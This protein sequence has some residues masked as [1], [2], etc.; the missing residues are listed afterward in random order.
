MR[1]AF[2]LYKM[3][4][5]R[6]RSNI[7]YLVLYFVVCT[8]GGGEGAGLRNSSTGSRRRRA[9]GSRRSSRSRRPACCP[10]PPAS[11]QLSTS[12]WLGIRRLGVMLDAGLASVPERWVSAGL[13]S[14]GMTELG[15]HQ[16][17]RETGLVPVLKRWVSAG[18]AL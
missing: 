10:G 6:I 16:L 12:G 2:G 8:V 14:C 13:P 18:M 17:T 3:C 11:S 15:W 7:A 4:I 9:A 1:F 5:I